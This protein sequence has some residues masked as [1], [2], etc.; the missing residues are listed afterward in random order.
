VEFVLRLR[1]VVRLNRGCTSPPA[2]YTTLP[3][4]VSINIYQNVQTHITVQYKFRNNLKEK[5]VLGRT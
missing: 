4:N 2:M 5:E 3:S 1:A